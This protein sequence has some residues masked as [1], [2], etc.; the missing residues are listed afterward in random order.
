MNEAPFFA[1]CEGFSGCR[2]L[3]MEEDITKGTGDG[4]EGL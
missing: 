2:I 1:A 3:R 4:L